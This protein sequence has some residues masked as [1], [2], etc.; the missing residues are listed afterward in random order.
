MSL[1]RSP[2]RDNS[3]PLKRINV[4]CQ[5][6]EEHKNTRNRL[7]LTSSDGGTGG[8]MAPGVPALLPKCCQCRRQGSKPFFGDCEDEES[9]FVE[10]C[11]T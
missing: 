11:S 9:A 6:S 5:I 4:R 1:L 10:V 3:L 2:I 7:Q 8:S